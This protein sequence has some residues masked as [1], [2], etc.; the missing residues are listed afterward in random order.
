MEDRQSRIR[1]GYEARDY[2]S[3]S[4]AK[5]YLEDIIAEFQS[6]GIRV[7]IFVDPAEEMIE[8]AKRTGT[9]RIELYTESYASDYAAN[10]NLAIAPYKLAAE[11]A[12]EV[13]IGLNA[14]HDL[15]LE[16]LQFFAQ[17]IPNLLE[18]SIGHALV[19]DALIYGMENTIQLYKRQ[20]KVIS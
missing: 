14:G 15:S 18:V 8:G 20:L 16:N 11:V 7:S 4:K 1:T 17:E 5:S 6:A 12:K 10:R 2:L 3:N 13:G 9:D 19:C